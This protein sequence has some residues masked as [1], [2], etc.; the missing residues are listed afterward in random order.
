MSEP[1]GRLAGRV[2]I[3]TG[4]GSGIGRAI[5]LGYAREGARVVAADLNGPAAEATAREG[6]G[7]IR[8]HA[9]DVTDEPAVAAMVAAALDWAPLGQP[10]LDVLVNSAAVQLHGQDGRCHAV[11]LDVWERT[12]RVNLRGPF[13]CCKHALPALIRSR[14]TIVN[15]AS[16]TAFQDLG[17]AYTAYA[18]SKGGIATLT[19]VVA[20]DYARD[21]VRV[22]AIVPGPTETNLTSQIFADPAIRDPLLARTPLGRLGRPED[23]VGVAIFLASADSA[24][25]TG[26]LF[27][28]DGGI[29]MA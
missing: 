6:G 2:A 16:P 21:G 1:R 10:R 11:D 12:L 3:V 22:N 25:A 29:T 14:G 26:A 24:Y 20:T 8:A 17:A 28:V 23:L 18:S 4:A 27:F 13:L 7:A 9:V 5:A 15:L 19:R